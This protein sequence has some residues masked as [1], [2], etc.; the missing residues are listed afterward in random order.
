MFGGTYLFVQSV[1]PEIHRCIAIVVY[2]TGYYSDKLKKRS[3]FIFGGLLVA[4]FG[5][6]MNILDLPVAAKY[7]GTFAIVA[8][9]YASVPGVVAWSV[10]ISDLEL[11]ANDSAKG[12]KQS[13]WQL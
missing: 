7:I 10:S 12:R 5:L 4:S 2:T 8:G 13:L 3:P 9:T 1:G 6:F 11:H